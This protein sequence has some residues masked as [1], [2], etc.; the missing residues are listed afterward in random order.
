MK[1]FLVLTLVFALL[2]VTF[3]P[4]LA[5]GGGTTGSTGSNGNGNQG[6]TGQGGSTSTTTGSQLYA[7]AG[8]IK[9]IDATKKTVTIDVLVG[10]R[11][12]TSYITTDTETGWIT[13]TVTA[14]T[15]LLLSGGTPIKFEDLKVNDPV[16]S[17]G[18]LS[19]DA[20]GALVWTAT[21]ITKG[22]LLINQ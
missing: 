13:V 16:S 15:R 12:L 17:N 20:S 9:A 19:T 6:A 18:I 1:K 11:L 7:L 22:A 8:Y 3:V 14:T 21:R 5:A 2:T 4:A 10:N